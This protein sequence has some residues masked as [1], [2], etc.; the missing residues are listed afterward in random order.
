MII[1]RILRKALCLLSYRLLAQ[2]I[3]DLSGK[4]II[5]TF[6]DGPDPV[7]TPKILELLKRHG[8]K[9]IFFVVG[10]CV[11]DNRQLFMQMI[12]EGHWIG[13]HTYSHQNIEKLNNDFLAN[14]ISRCQN[15]IS[16]YDNA[17]Y[18]LFR[19]PRGM[20]SVRN[21][22]F[23]LKNNFNIILWN[24]DSK[25]SNLSCQEIICALRTTVKKKEIVLFHDDGPLCVEIL[26]ELIPYWKSRGMVL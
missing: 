13:N 7:N 5:L 6:D 1:A 26:E 10:K 9:A 18:S 8:I 4:D 2:K 20:M 19:P 11:N 14:E 15:I 25:D 17:N 16:E 22:L 12:E 21:F 23:I 3:P 24:V